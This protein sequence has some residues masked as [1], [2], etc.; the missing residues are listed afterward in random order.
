MMRLILMVRRAKRP[1]LIVT[2]GPHAFTRAIAIEMAHV[3]YF[4]M[5]FN[6]KSQ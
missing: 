4:G 2:G 3:R 5:S 1:R 6:G